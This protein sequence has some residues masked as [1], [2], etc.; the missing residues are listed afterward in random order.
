MPLPPTPRKIQAAWRDQGDSHVACSFSL[1]Y[2]LD[3]DS[4][5]DAPGNGTAIVAALREHLGMRAEVRWSGMQAGAITVTF[6]G[7]R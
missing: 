3:E 1:G 2:K 4:D 6:A 7:N 5:L